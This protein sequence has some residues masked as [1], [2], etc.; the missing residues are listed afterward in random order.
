MSC[1][2]L[3]FFFL[4]YEYNSA[5]VA[6][7][8]ALV[9]VYVMVAFSIIFMDAFDFSKPYGIF[10]GSEYLLFC[11]QFPQMSVFNIFPFS[12]GGHV[13]VFVA[14]YVSGF[15]AAI[16]LFT[17][18]SL[19]VFLVCVISLQGRLVPIMYSAADS[20][21]RTMLLCLV[22]TDCGSAWSLDV[23]LGWS[24]GDA[25]VDGW[26]IRLF[27]VFICLVYMGS[28]IPKLNDRYWLNGEVVRN[29]VF[30]G[31]WGKRIACKFIAK[32]TR[33]L[34]AC[35]LC[36]EYSAPF[37]L[38]VHETTLP[39]VIAGIFLHGGVTVFLRVGYF[40]PLMCIALLFFLNPQ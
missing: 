12:R 10:G 38:L 28:S 14:F 39:A 9:C 30:S 29:A 5:W 3:T 6:L 26:A 27:Q 23:V 35:S 36:Y 31:I 19:F 37:F 34:S 15:F 11:K 24:K 21:L 40:G 17:G 33:I 8:R 18:V 7:L 16:G 22:L 13:S 2:D 4:G 32:N 25:V 20:V 1:G